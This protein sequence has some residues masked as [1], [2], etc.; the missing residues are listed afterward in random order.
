[1]TILDDVTTWVPVAPLERLGVDR[2]A[3]AMVGPW[4]VAVFRVAGDDVYALSNFDPFSQAYVLSR[5][6]VGT[7]GDVPKVASPVYK[8]SFDLRTGVCL[9]DP[10]VAVRVF[11]VRVVEGVVE[12]GVPPSDRS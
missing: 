10:A 9:D 3:G 12:V 8:Q 5:G 6:I 4:Q 11:P 7:R 1:M 2:G